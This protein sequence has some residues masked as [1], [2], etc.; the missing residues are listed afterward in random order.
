M[1]PTRLRCNLLVDPLAVADAKPRLSWVLE[2]DGIRQSAYQIEV[3]SARRGN[4][5]LWDSG[6]VKS[7]WTLEDIVEHVHEALARHQPTKA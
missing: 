4:A 1:L 5:D 6:Q 3:S 2:G 7:D